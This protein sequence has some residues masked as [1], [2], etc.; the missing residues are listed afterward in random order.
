MSTDVKCR[1]LYEF[2]IC[3]CLGF[4]CASAVRL[5]SNRVA[6]VGKYLDHSLHRQ[7]YIGLEHLGYSV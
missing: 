5:S 3:W 4:L 2:M 7:H 6:T 1:E